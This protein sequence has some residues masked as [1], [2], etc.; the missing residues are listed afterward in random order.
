MGTVFMAEQ[1]QPVQRKVALM[2][3]PPEPSVVNSP[4]HFGERM[5]FPLL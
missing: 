1:T 2:P 3:I 4:V 5:A